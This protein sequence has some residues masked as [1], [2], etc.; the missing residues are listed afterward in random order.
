MRKLFAATATIFLLVACEDSDPLKLGCRAVSELNKQSIVEGL[1][2]K[3]KNKLRIGHAMAVRSDD[4]SRM[5]FLAA[6]VLP[7]VDGENSP[8]GVW[9][10]NRAQE[11]A[12]LMLAMPG[13]AKDVT[14]YPDATRTKMEASRYSSGYREALRCLELVKEHSG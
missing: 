7:S 10:T 13:I 2:S 12:S 8:I 9:V 14:V 3:Y 4:F 1:K 11:P 6:K 5:Y